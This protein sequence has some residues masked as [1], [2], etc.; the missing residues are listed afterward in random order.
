MLAQRQ[1]SHLGFCGLG[2]TER[3][4]RDGVSLLL[5][6]AM[7]AAPA[8]AQ[9]PAP[10][11]SSSRTTAYDGTYVGVSAENNSRGNT[12]AGG[13]DRTVGYA[14][15]RGCRTFRAPAR[16]TIVNGVAQA[17]WGEYTLRGSPTPD[18]RLTMRTGFG[19]KFEGRIDGRH[20]VE[21]QLVGYCAYKLT[22]RKTS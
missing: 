8:R 10:A 17:R 4:L 22:W 1:R 6:V 7:L 20:M 16:L 3:T 9:G 19:Q 15:S 12:L 21:G 13:R 18:G 5:A 2:S 11:A 14:G